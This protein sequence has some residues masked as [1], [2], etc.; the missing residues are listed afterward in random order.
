M[1][2]DGNQPWPETDCAKGWV[3]RCDCDR[4]RRDRATPIPAS[5]PAPRDALDAHTDASNPSGDAK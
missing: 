1:A 5:S 4:C 2:S 3:S